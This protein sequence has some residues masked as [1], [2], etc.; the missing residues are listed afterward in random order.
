MISQ[1]IFTFFVI[2][3]SIKLTK[4][5]SLVDLPNKRKVHTGNIPLA[6]GISLFFSLIYMLKFGNFDDFYLNSIIGYSLL[7][8]LVGIIDDKYNLN[9]GSKLALMTFAIFFLIKEGLVVNSLGSYDF[10]GELNLGT[11]QVMFTFIAVLLL[12]NGFNYIDGIDGICIALFINGLIF[13]YFLNFNNENFNNFLQ[14]LILISTIL[15]LFNISILKLPKIF[16]GD[17]GS[18]MLGFIASF[19]LIYSFKILNIHPAKL[20]W[21]F[22]LI[23]FD[24]LAVNI[25][26]FIKNKKIFTAGNDHLHHILL[27]KFKS[28]S[29]TVFIMLVINSL[30]GY[31]GIFISDINNLFSIF[32]FIVSF[33]FY[34]ILRRIY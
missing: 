30:F 6:G 13:L 17:G 19:L 27:K 14:N 5:I 11:M 29:K 23:I 25:N 4:K 34:F 24:F 26:R 9:V 12:I 31:S 20:I 3:L 21:C 1:G 22:N 7:I 8:S 32:L 10:L 18:L 2:I 16:L 28:S 15:L 33:L